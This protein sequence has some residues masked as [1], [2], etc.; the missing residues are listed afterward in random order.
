MIHRS[1]SQQVTDDSA[2]AR[3]TPCWLACALTSLR[4]LLAYFHIFSTKTSQMWDISLIGRNKSHDSHVTTT[5]YSY[6]YAFLLIITAC[7]RV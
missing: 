4:V 5:D 2:G 1:T 6:V 3:A 7:P